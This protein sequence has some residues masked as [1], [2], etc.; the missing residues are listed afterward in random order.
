MTGETAEPST[1][2]R[3]E[4]GRSGGA[5]VLQD[6]KLLSVI[7]CHRA[8]QVLSGPHGRG[9]SSTRDRENRIPF[10]YQIHPAEFPCY[11]KRAQENSVT[12]AWSGKPRDELGVFRFASIVF[13]QV[14]KIIA[15]LG[16]AAPFFRL[17][18]K[19]NSIGV[20]RE[21]AKELRGEVT[22]R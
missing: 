12:G 3:G 14:G 11:E 20:I 2:V 15:C 10:D 18:E 19:R 5:T 16:V 9:N 4:P 21:V 6:R 13:D 17:R 22:R 1:K 8:R 7:S